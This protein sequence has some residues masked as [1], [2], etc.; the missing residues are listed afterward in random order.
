MSQPPFRLRWP[1]L[2]CVLAVAV[3]VN[4][5]SETELPTQS[6]APPDFPGE[7]PEGPGLFK[8]TAD[9]AA[10]TV[11]C[12]GVVA[13]PGKGGV[14]YDQIVGQQGVYVRLTS[15]NVAYDGAT[16]SFNVTVQNLT[17]TAMGTADGATRDDD[18]VRIFFHSLPIVVDGTGAISVA[19]ATGQA[20]FTTAEQPYFQYG[21]KLGGVDQ[22]ELGADGI[23]ATGET[24]T[25]KNWQ[26]TIPPTVNQFSFTVLV[27]TEMPVG[28][29]ES[30]APEITSILPPLLV[31]GQS[32]TIEGHRFNQVP[33]SNT[34]TIGGT[35]ATVTGGD[36]TSLTVTVPCVASGSQNVSVTQGGMRGVE[37][38][39]TVMVAQRPLRAGESIVLTSSA[40]SYCNELPATFTDSR[41][42]VSVFSASTSPSSNASF[43]I[44][45]NT[46]DE[47]AAVVSNNTVMRPDFASI[48]LQLR[49]EL[50][51]QEERD[52][53]H[54]ELLERNA[55]EYLRLRANPPVAARPDVTRDAPLMDTPP[56]TRTFRVANINAAG[57]FCNSYYVLSATRVY[58]NGKLAIYED[59][60][61]PDAFKVALNP[62]MAANMEKIGDQ[63]NADMEP[64]VRNNFGD[65]LRR[66]A[67][68]DNNGVMIA[69]F[70]PRINTSFSGVAGFVVSCD[71]F[72]ND[73]TNTPAV[74]G[75][76]TGTGSNGASNFGEFF[77]AYQPAVDGTGYNSGNTP[78]NW[79]RT[80]RS[81]F[82]HESKHVASQAARVENNAPTY[83]ASWL[84]EGT[85]R[86]A[87]ELWMR[88]AVDNVGWKANTGYGD[89]FNPVNLYCDHRPTGW[90]ECDANTRRP[91]NL[92]QRHFSSLYTHLYGQNA[93]LLSPFGATAS[94]NGSYFYAVSWSLVRY[95]IDRYGVSDADFL[96]A[97]TQSTTSG[98]TNLTARAG[99]SI[100]QLLG[101]WNL[102]LAADDHPA[103]VVPGAD[104]QFATWNFRDI[105][106]GMNSDFP[107]T[108]SR[109]YPQVPAA[110]SFGA[111]FAPA[112]VSTLRGGGSL[113][114]EFSG[115]QALPQ[116]LRLEGYFGGLP[117]ADL[118][119][120]ITRIH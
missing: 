119:I 85:A 2:A 112:V 66:D 101:G 115:E 35:T 22:G 4:A 65:I 3:V 67:L 19:N 25:A 73:D 33:G 5:C 48:P 83:E 118:R 111:P 46:T 107:G 32:A 7:L 117:S 38:T 13:V 57:N 12:G 1:R 94:D 77:Y 97:L 108:Y 55:E 89:A 52:R 75:P 24:S 72:A 61:T 28:E 43:R 20:T 56:L 58:Y 29:L 80:I 68:T 84:E 70:T 79:Y 45:A 64:I 106:R 87:E 27:A 47:P 30:A 71:Q 51:R 105:Y 90:P 53:T 104:N 36:S 113:W 34:V 6:V 110:T 18:G 37:Q 86:H 42:I 14:L 93:R 17:T 41:Y 39:A 44:S 82:I 116:L 98:A 62:T 10:R 11:D 31:P 100:D 114:Y 95:A 88:N 103:Q 78:D 109:V 91:A 16:F 9:V 21:G 76:Y 92:M 54:H 99:V 74:G 81:T 23:L 102:A 40:D 63:F 120:A 50:T 8:C 60:A 69:L 15:S 49:A 96:T 26:M 59:D